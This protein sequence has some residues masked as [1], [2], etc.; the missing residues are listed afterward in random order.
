M[1]I[2]LVALRNS[3]YYSGCSLKWAFIPGPIEIQLRFLK[4]IERKL[5]PLGHCAIVQKILP[6]ES[7]LLILDPLVDI[8]GLDDGDGSVEVRARGEEQLEKTQ[9]LLGQPRLRISSFKC[10][11]A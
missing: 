3:S 5:V 4:N 11:S 6:V 10:F 7:G 2:A 1:P 8:P 9:L